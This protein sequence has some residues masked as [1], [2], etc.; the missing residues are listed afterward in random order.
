MSSLKI[1]GNVPLSGSVEVLGSVSSA[2]RMIYAACYSSEDVVLDNVPKVKVIEEQLAVLESIGVTYS[3]LTDTKLVLNAGGINTH[4]VKKPENF[5]SRTIY[6][7][8]G[9]LLYRFRKAVIPKIDQKIEYNRPLNRLIE[10]WKKFNISVEESDDFYQLDAS[11]VKNSEI[12][13]KSRTQMGTDHAII[14]SCFIKGESVVNTASEEVETDDLINFINDL[15]GNIQRVSPDVIKI[16][17]VESFK[18]GHYVVPCSKNDIVLYSTAALITKGNVLIN[19]VKK[20][21]VTPFSYFLS[22]IGASFDFNQ[23]TMRVW[24]SNQDLEPQR[25][26]ITYYPGL[27]HDWYGFILLILMN[28]RGTSYLHNTSFPEP[29][30]SIQDLNRMGAD[31]DLLKPS[32]ADFV[33][34]MT[35]DYYDIKE[36]GEPSSVVK[37]EGPCRL[38]GSKIDIS[39]YLYGEILV[40]ASL[41]AE[42][43]S[44]IFGFENAEMRFKNLYKNLTKIGAKISV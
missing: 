35:S 19:N 4:E 16:T 18:G 44:E 1:E 23:D 5:N 12:S 8:S 37:I 20:D 38:K 14:T 27:I 11:S 31:I 21:Y 22:K 30:E 39:G 3:W 36:K 17:G 29:F 10:T 43:K 24:Y 40:L 42:G 2:T 28:A 25:A 6:L 15:G 9:P 41:F 26:E 32:Q 13:F 7:I 34:L 33:P